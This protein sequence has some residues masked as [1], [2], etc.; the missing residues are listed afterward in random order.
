MAAPAG[1]DAARAAAVARHAGL[2]KAARE[3]GD[4]ASALSHYEVLA[5]L[6][7][8]NASHRAAALAARQAIDGG[9]REALAAGNAARR[10]GDPGRAKSAYL[11]A[12]ALDPGNAQAAAALRDVEQQVMSRAQ[13]ERAAR[14]RSMEAV[15]AAAKARAASPSSADSY[16]LEQRLELLRAGDIGAGVREAQAWVEANPGNRDGRARLASAVAERA[17][18]AERKGQRESAIRLYEQANAL[19]GEPVPEW[20]AKARQLRRA[21]GEAP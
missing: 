20:T 13:A 8:A 12:L 18:D 5:L 2:A 9:V 6:D 11:T 14:A 19:R 7:P 1:T 4:P 15:V 3:A 16:D 21:L 17:S 10:G